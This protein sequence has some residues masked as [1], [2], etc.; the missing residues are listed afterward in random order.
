MLCLNHKKLSSHLGL[1]WEKKTMSK[2]IRVTFKKKK[3]V[4]YSAEM[5]FRYNLMIM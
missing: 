1:K 4:Q 2:K 3:K 5:V